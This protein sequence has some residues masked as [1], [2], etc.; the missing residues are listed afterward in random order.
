MA[1]SSGAFFLQRTGYEMIDKTTQLNELADGKAGNR[2]NPNRT[3]PRIEHPLRDLE[4][5]AVSLS[6]QEIVNTLV[7]MVTGHQHRP[8]DQRVERIGDHSFEC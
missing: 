2:Y 4:R 7:L 8:A 6:D 3:R 5:A 1:D